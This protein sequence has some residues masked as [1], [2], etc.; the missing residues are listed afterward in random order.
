[1]VDS[2]KNKNLIY[3]TALTNVG[4]TNSARTMFGVRY[5]VLDLKT[6]SDSED[7]IFT[8]TVFHNF[9]PRFIMD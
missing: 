3:K 7:F 5:L 1:M 2:N 6:F 8:G 4:F 9:A